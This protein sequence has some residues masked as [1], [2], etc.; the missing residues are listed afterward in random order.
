MACIY[1]LLLLRNIPL[2]VQ[3]L[4]TDHGYHGLLPI[5]YDATHGSYVQCPKT[6]S[7]TSPVDCTFDILA[8]GCVPE[9]CSD[10]QM[11]TEML[12]PH[13]YEFFRS[14]LGHEKVTQD[15]VLQGNMS[16]YNSELWV[17]YAHHV[18]LCLYLLNGSVRATAMRSAGRLDSWLGD[19]L[20]QHCFDAIRTNGDPKKTQGRVKTV[21]KF[22]KCYL[23]SS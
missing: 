6:A 22:R 1:L 7:P 20:M 19:R 13:K 10:A 8:H 5:V 21:F 11:H 2:E 9:P 4:V 16:I 18:G 14:R 3:S 15:V 12:A 23:R 17:P